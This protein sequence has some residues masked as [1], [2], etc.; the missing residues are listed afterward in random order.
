MA[1]TNS[2]REKLSTIY[3]T[4]KRAYTRKTNSAEREMEEEE[5]STHVYWNDYQSLN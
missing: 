2:K 4:H 3:H 5:K 1:A